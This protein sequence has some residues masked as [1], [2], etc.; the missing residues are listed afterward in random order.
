MLFPTPSPEHS[1]GEAIF[2]HAFTPFS[3]KRDT[4][5]LFVYSCPIRGPSP[6]TYFQ[7]NLGR[8][9]LAQVS[10]RANFARNM[11]TV[12]VRNAASFFTSGARNSLRLFTD[13]YCDKK[14]ALRVLCSS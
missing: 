10:S 1:E 12:F 5:S 14:P 9:E 3:D 2:L 6:V 8:Q 4:Y 7:R 11:R 13:D